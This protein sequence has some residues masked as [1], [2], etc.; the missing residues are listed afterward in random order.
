MEM[1]T[2]NP[3][4][5]HGT[6]SCLLGSKLENLGSKIG[7]SGFPNG[8]CQSDGRALDFKQFSR[9]YNGEISVP[10]WG[11]CRSELGS[12]CSHSA[13]WVDSGPGGFTSRPGGCP[14]GKSGFPNR[15]IWVPKWG[16]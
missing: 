3:T 15:E 12:V 13:L 4:D 8:D 11:S 9:F 2:A 7:R 14:E 5:R 6:L 1:A 16:W 10:E